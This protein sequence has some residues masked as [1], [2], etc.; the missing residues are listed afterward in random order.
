M[1]SKIALA[2]LPILVLLLVLGGAAKM[3][4]VGKDAEPGAL[5]RLGPAILVPA[6]W[7]R[8][9]LIICAVGEVVLTAGLLF[10][11]NA[12][13]R[14]ATVA[15]FAIST[16]VLLDLRRRRPDVGCGCFGE[17]SAT[18]IGLRSIGRT[19]VLTGIAL[20][21]AVE[22]AGGAAVVASLSW[23][24]VAWAAAA[25]L[26]L[27]ALSPEVEETVARLRYR[28]PCEQRDLPV[29]RSLSRLT[30]STVWRSHR[31]LLLSTEPAD[32]WRELCW[33]FFA[34]P[35]R[36]GDGE[37][38]EVVFAVYLSG[39]HA[40][41]RGAVVAADGSSLASLPESMPVSAGH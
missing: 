11:N 7:R 37:N 19:T 6:K 3:A 2:G 5:T 40:P 41:V 35:G 16:Y 22:S 33:R 34:Y 20:A 28:A 9:A 15:F 27:V 25:V 23:T 24:L 38:V 26:I 32:M 39:R 1:L 31:A 4:T 8:P 13:P 30:S 29:E 18:P 36:T 17:V 10:W 21:V 12:V 14:W